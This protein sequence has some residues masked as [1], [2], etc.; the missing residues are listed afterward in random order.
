MTHALQASEP[1]EDTDT[2]S[3]LDMSGLATDQDSS[4][5]KH[6]AKERIIV[7]DA[8]LSILDTPSMQTDKVSV[9]CDTFNPSTFTPQLALKSHAFLLYGFGLSLEKVAASVP[10]IKP[11]SLG[12]GL[13]VPCCPMLITN[14]CWRVA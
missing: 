13:I 7:V 1:I 2:L 4:Q 11:S 6:E 14:E 12:N 8:A 5:T 3:A 10:A 9:D